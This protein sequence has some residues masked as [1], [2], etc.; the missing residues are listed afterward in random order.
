MRTGCGF[1]QWEEAGHLLGQGSGGAAKVSA[2][3]LDKKLNVMFKG[4]KDMA[5]YGAI[6]QKQYCFQ[7]DAICLVDSLD[8]LRFASVRMDAAMKLM[9]VQ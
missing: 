9:Q 3:N 6:V 1:S 4:S 7:D 8:G 2:L 5:R